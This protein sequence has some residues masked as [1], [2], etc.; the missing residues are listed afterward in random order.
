VKLIP[1]HITREEKVLKIKEEA[2]DAWREEHISSTEND[3]SRRNKKRGRSDDFFDSHEPKRANIFHMLIVEPN[4]NSH[5]PS[6]CLI[7]HSNA[8]WG[9]LH[10]NAG[11]QPSTSD[12]CWSQQIFVVQQHSPQ[13]IVDVL[14]EHS[15]SQLPR[16]CLWR[17]SFLHVVVRLFS[18]RE[19]PVP[20]SKWGAFISPTMRGFEWLRSE[21]ACTSVVHRG[22]E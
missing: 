22:R 7:S 21:F 20:V 5:D 13:T 18:F 1:H 8:P 11:W 12:I 9:Q 2:I 3:T 4:R 17:S 16:C 10:R 14:K 19:N 6:R 15:C